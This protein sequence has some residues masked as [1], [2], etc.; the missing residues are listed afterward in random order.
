VLL[1]STD[2]ISVKSSSLIA[3]QSSISFF[4]FSSFHS[5]YMFIA[6]SSS[7][8]SSLI[9]SDSCFCHG[10]CILQIICS[11][12]VSVHAGFSLIA[13]W[14]KLVSIASQEVAQVKNKIV[15]FFGLYFSFSSICS[16]STIETL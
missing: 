3:S 2:I 10:L 5:A 15:F 7:Q 11:S 12:S 1:L 8:T 6:L 14:E 13:V 16:L 4:I 9:Y